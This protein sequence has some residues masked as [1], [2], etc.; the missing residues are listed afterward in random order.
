[1]GRRPR[2]GEGER[3]VADS[4]MPEDPADDERIGDRGDA[5]SPSAAAWAAEGGHGRVGV[6]DGAELG[7]VK[8]IEGADDQWAFGFAPI[9]W[10]EQA[11]QGIGPG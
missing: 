2:R 1:L 6:V 10:F 5:I 3:L 8:W 4:D 9:G 7:A 11:G